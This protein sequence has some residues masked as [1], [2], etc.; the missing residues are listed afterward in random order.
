MERIG[1]VQLTLVA[2]YP[3]ERV[4]GALEPACE[5]QPSRPPRHDSG[6]VDLDVALDERRSGCHLRSVAAED[7]VG[8]P[9]RIAADVRE[10][11]T[12][13]RSREA[14]IARPRQ[15]E[16]ERADDLGRLA[17]RAARQ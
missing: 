6:R 8:K 2:E 14:D 3:G 1:Q 16:M 4:V 13:Q 5:Q 12:P 9:D 7:L 15:V 11:A 10:R 17:D